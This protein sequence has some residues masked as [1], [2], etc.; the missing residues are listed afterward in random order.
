ML[1]ILEAHGLSKTKTISNYLSRAAVRGEA[2]LYV[3]LWAEV[4]QSPD[5]GPSFYLLRR[6]WVM[7]ATY[8]GMVVALAVWVVTIVACMFG[9]GGSPPTDMIVGVPIGV[10]L[11]VSAVAC[12]REAGRYVDYQMEELVASIAAKRA[13]Q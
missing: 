10:A 8:D 9:V 13:D 7:A 3:R 5:L 2:R 12:S 1:T 11:L 6:Y 4:R